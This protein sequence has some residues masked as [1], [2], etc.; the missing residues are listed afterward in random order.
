MRWNAASP[1]GSSPASNCR[2]SS[3]QSRQRLFFGIIFLL[4]ISRTIVLALT[5]LDPQ[6]SE[7]LTIGE[8]FLCT[9][10]VLIVFNVVDLLPLDGLIF[11]R[12]QLRFIFLSG[13][14]YD[15]SLDE[16]VPLYFNRNKKVHHIAMLHDLTERQV[17]DQ[18]DRYVGFDWER[19]YDD[20]EAARAAHLAARTAMKSGTGTTTGA[21]PV[22]VST[23]ERVHFHPRSPHCLVQ[24][25]S[26]ASF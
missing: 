8:A 16:S 23:P 4:L 20:L 14:Y 5:Q 1:S 18:M 9:W 21:A 12:L 17:A 2:A 13:T 11:I 15:D 26:L 19:R 10:L 6:V 3:A 24:T 25:P 22:M 7:P